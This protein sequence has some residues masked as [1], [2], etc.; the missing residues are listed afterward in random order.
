MT[1]ERL[2]CAF[3]YNVHDS[4]VSFAINNKVVLVLE[5]ERIFRQKKKRCNHDEMEI[6]IKTGL[7]YL[8]KKP[9]DVTRWAMTTLNNPLLTRPDIIDEKTTFPK[10]PYLKEITILGIR[11]KALV[12]NHHLSHAATYLFSKFNQAIITTCDGGGDHDPKIGIGEC[13]ALYKGNGNKIVRHYNVDSAELITGKT[14]AT[15]SV[16]IYSAKPC[17]GKLMALASFGKVRNEYLEKLKTIYRKI[18]TVDYPVGEKIL[19]ENFPNLRGTAFGSNPSEEAKDFCATVQFFF[20]KQ[21]IKNTKS[22]V[23]KIY[24]DG[25]GFILA[26]GT[27]LNLDLNSLL[28]KELPEMQHF[29]A[30]C[31]DDTGQSLGAL[32]MLIV[33][34][35]GLRPDIKLPYLGMG[36]EN[37]SHTEE[38]I[39]KVTDILNKDGIAILHNGKSEIGPRA[40]GNRSF[41]TRAD[42]IGVKRKLSEEIKQREPYRPVAPVT[43]EDKVNEYFTGPKSSPY[44]LYKYDVIDSKKEDLVGAVHHDGSARVQ[45][46]TSESNSFLYDLIKSYGEKTGTYVL[47][48]TSLNLK[49]DPIANTLDDSLKIY[50]KID[51]PKV[52]VYNGS[53]EKIDN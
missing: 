27:G 8:G 46:V 49:G 17:E 50:E 32:G 22:I 18:E 36:S 6:L 15:C 45:T 2:Y 14:Y 16:F 5:A 19:E 34:E 24:K 26:G 31:C 29:I 53:I 37:V 42:S 3:A 48:N 9:E 47:L 39:Q 43:T 28:Q 13:F 35:T 38:T 51:G 20:S 44:M 41:I 40:L 52:L 21:R 30:P 25:D 7:K 12:I 11:T 4:S 33:E 23:D 10:E 1:K